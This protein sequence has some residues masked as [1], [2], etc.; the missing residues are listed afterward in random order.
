M[1]EIVTAPESTQA[2]V[3]TKP[4]DITTLSSDQIAEKLKSSDPVNTVKPAETKPAEVTKLAEE[5]WFDKAHGFKTKEDAIKSFGEAANKIRE[6]AE[7]NK[8]V[9]SELE[10]TKQTRTLSPEEQQK[11]QAIKQW[12]LENKT[13][14]DF[15][16]KTI[17]EEVNQTKKEEDSVKE[18]IDT[19]KSWYE[20]FQ[21]DDKRKELWPKM[22]ET[23]NKYG[24]DA[25]SRYQGFMAS[26]DKNP[27]AVLEAMAFKE[28]FP[29]ILENLKKEAIEQYKEQLKQ[30]AE[31]EKKSKTAVPGGPKSLAGDIDVSKM[32]ASE[33]A[34]LLPRGE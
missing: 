6:L 2:P 1:E 26:V 18:V 17:L 5:E 15:L 27:L 25:Q 21:K 28:N 11:E 33:I 32:S 31:A 19:R 16:K 4:E 34:D 30:A 7:Q 8:Q 12:Q 20:E 22:E 3:E 23:F 9:M 29:N 13:A 14:I 24:Y 10:K